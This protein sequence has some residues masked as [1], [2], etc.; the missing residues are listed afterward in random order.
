MTVSLDEAGAG[1]AFAASRG[2]FE[3]LVCFLDGAEAAGLEHAELEDRVDTDGRA[4]LRQLI[5]DHFDLRAQREAR[6]ETV[7]DAHGVER[8]AVE[9]GHQ[10]ALTTV[11]GE[12]TVT[13][14]AYRRRGHANLHPAD[15]LLNL[16]VDK[17]SHG[18]RRLAAIEASRGSYD[19]AVEAIERAT[20]QQLGKR[21]AEQLAQRAAVDFDAFYATRQP[22]AGQ[23][24][25]VLALSADGKGIVM[26]P[27]A[28]RPATAKAAQTS[29]TKLS[30]RLSKG[31]KRN[32]KRLAEVGA[33]YDITP[34]ARTSADVL[35]RSDDEQAREAT[36]APVATNKW[37]K[38][39]VT[40]DAATVIA[41]LFDEA[42]R[43]DPA[44]ERV[45]V[46]LVDG[47]NHQIDRIKAEAKARTL[48][49]PILCDLCRAGNYAD[50]P[51]CWAR[52]PCRGGLLEL[53]ADRAVGIVA[54]GGS[55]LSFDRTQRLAEGDGDD[56][57]H[58][59]FGSVGGARRRV[60]DGVGPPR[61]HAVVT[62][63]QA[64]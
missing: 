17:H 56:W 41:S 22:P 20:G 36:P 40:A 54:R 60:P 55:M 1:D 34:I 39:S 9:A 3:E 58:E 21:Q 12:V 59:G 63:V 6:L 24:R 37:L 8:G 10:R 2:R 64:R 5:Q 28:L 4:V 31:E 53:P 50:T 7:V 29:T 25:D 45:W 38:A 26:R 49:V 15:G 18:L 57:P 48:Q 33:V 52:K 30:T 51:S 19:A 42:Q 43:R 35:A 61:L 23:S 14:L 46:A 44:H 27:D 47:N 62:G 32:R 16:P 11:F 13:R